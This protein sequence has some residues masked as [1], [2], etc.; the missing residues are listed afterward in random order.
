MVS[1]MLVSQDDYFYCIAWICFGVLII[2][3]TEVQW[4]PLSTLAM[5]GVHEHFHCLLFHGHA[6]AKHSLH[7]AEQIVAR[8]SLITPDIPRRSPP[9]YLIQTQDLPTDIF[10]VMPTDNDSTG[11]RLASHPPSVRDFVWTG[12]AAETEFKV[13][14]RPGACAALG[15]G[16]AVKCGADII[17][18]SRVTRLSF[19]IEVVAA[20]DVARL[21]SDGNAQE[22]DTRMESVRANVA[23]IAQ[24]D[25]MFEG[26]LGEGVQVRR[27]CMLSGL[28]H[29]VGVG[30]RY[31]S[32][33]VSNRRS[34]DSF[35]E[36]IRSYCALLLRRWFISCNHSR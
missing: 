21:V 24:E 20:G 17:E 8:R 30:I 27:R 19:K 12:S 35:C 34:D 32:K 4:S 16:T 26:K 15:A 18:G 5:E 2:H 3:P 10:E 23:R 33:I 29:A 1:V 14:C 9:E 28:G 11:V 7:C 36:C 22:L 25:I 6:G 31:G 13:G